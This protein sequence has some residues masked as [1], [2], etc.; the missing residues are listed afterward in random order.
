MSEDFTMPE[1]LNSYTTSSTLPDENKRLINTLF[2]RLSGLNSEEVSF[3]ANEI[4]RLMRNSGFADIDEQ[5]NWQLDP[6]PMMVSSQDWEVIS[7][8]IE[9][10]MLLLNKVLIDLN[11]DQSTLTHGI[12]A[13]K[14]LMRHPFY[15]ADTHQVPSQNQGVFLNAFDIGQDA[16]G[17]Y[18]VLHDHCQFPR[19]LGLLL[20][21]RIVAR[22]VMSEEFTECGV[23]RIAGFFEQLQRAISQETAALTDPRIVILCRGPDDQYYSEQAYL[24]T[25]MGYTLVRS[26]DLTVRKGQ[27][28]LKALDGLRKVDVI[29][30]WI[31]DRYL[32]SLE[33]VDYSAFGIPGLIHAVR[34]QNVVLLNPLG[35]GAIQI[36]AIHNNLPLAAK[37]LINESLLLRQQETFPIDALEEQNWAGFELRS[38][39][40]PALKFD[41]EKDRA[42]IAKL[43]NQLPPEDLY[44]RK[45]LILS[46]APFWHESGVVSKPVIMRC[47]ALLSQGQVFILPSAM[48]F[49]PRAVRADGKMDIKDT[50]VETI[51]PPQ[52]QAPS[53]PKSLQSNADLA[54][55]EGLLPSRTA[56]NLFWL[57]CAVERSENVIRLVRVFIDKFTELAIYPDEAHRNALLRFK[58]GI[59]NQALIYPYQ[60]SVPSDLANPGGGFKELVVSLINSNQFVGGLFSSITMVVQSALQ[61]RELLSYDS[62]RIIENLEEEIYNFTL[63]NEQ[64]PTHRLQTI[65]D[66]LI[67]LI[68]A[69][70]GSIQ[71]SL[72]K[73]NGAFM[74]E[75]G[76]RLERSNQ[77]VSMIR[78]LLQSPFPE[79]EQQNVLDI[80]LVAQ[81][82]AITHRRR[83]RAFQSIETGL[84]LLLLDAEYPRSLAHQIQ[85]ITELCNSLPV[86]A[87][88]GFLSTTEKILLQLKASF[89]LADRYTLTMTNADA[90]S[91]LAS[92]LDSVTSHLQ[93]FSEMMQTQ[94][95]SHTK[96]ASQLHWS[97]IGTPTPQIIESPTASRTDSAAEPSSDH[98][99][100]EEGK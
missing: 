20:E 11:G 44:W 59:E 16:N 43:I 71:D 68:M 27:V 21:N 67:G 50:W 85:K 94:Y 31:E 7:R 46:Q 64:T 2:S 22:R 55:V 97:G 65:L 23:L 87:K 5:Q 39:I 76:K 81:V 89:A 77:L 4:R 88:P 40:D 66:R 28:W 38:Y 73:S 58:M 42:A 32:D 74:I 91:G 26:A 63:I 36:P 93:K 17:E 92:L 98:H 72:S 47:Y 78:N 80:V 53:I 45:K 48:C 30:R 25:Y 96:P 18:F 37:H 29:L 70:N 24:A 3:R 99:Q 83:Y 62:L 79:A 95:F 61:V 86:K 9:Q 15:L 60:F 56:E 57:G 33:Q 6:L 100:D 12:F 82:S 14:H 41:G 49:T 90:S 34:S 52:G 84:E 10:R 8:G 1:W 13:T 19:G 54:L 51:G 75:I 35:N 69:F